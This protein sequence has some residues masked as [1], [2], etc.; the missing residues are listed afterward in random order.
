MSRVRAVLIDALGTLVEL[1]SPGPRLRARLEAE[2][3]M[4]VGAAVAE[5]GFAAEISYYLVNQMRGRDAA[6]L[7][8]LRDDCAAVMHEALG[9]P[10]LE[11]AAVRRAML[12]ALEFA[13]FPDALPALTALRERGLRVV[14]ASNWDCSLPGWLERCGLSRLLDGAVSSAV[15]GAAKPDPAVFVAALE[16]AGAEPAEAVHVGDSLEGDVAG[17]RAAG[18]RPILLVRAGEPPG[19]VEVVRTLEEVSSLV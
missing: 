19:G 5:R 7:E 11:R 2:T 13:P 6:G 17:A 1:E 3:G 14:V 15:A 16:L 4:D 10:G 18:V 8:A 12:D 9:V